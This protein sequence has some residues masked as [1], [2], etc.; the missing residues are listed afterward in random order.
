MHI[1]QLSNQFDALRG[2]VRKTV[3][4]TVTDADG[5][6]KDFQLKANIQALQDSMKRLGD[7]R[8]K[9]KQIKEQVLHHA[10]HGYNQPGLPRQ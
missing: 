7:G 3:G 9:T 6:M 1:S 2:G 5:K 10:V 4:S 8:R